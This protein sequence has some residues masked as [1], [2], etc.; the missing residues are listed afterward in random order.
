MHS[1]RQFVRLLSAPIAC[2]IAAPLPIARATAWLQNSSKAGDLATVRNRIIQSLVGD[3]GRDLDVAASALVKSQTEAGT[4]AG[5]DYEDQSRSVWKTAVQLINALQIAG[6]YAIANFAEEKRRLLPA[7][8]AALQWWISHDPKNP[9]WWWNQIGV[10]RFVG[11]TAVFLGDALAADQRPA[12]E[13]IL[14]RAD[15]TKWTGQNLVWGCQIQ[16][17]RGLVT[18]EMKTVEQGFQRMYEEVTTAPP[19]GEGIEPDF[20]FHQH[21]SQL[22]SGGYGLNFAAD[23]G[24]YIAATGT[25]PPRFPRISSTSTRVT[26]SRV[27]PG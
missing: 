13:K 18:G 12:T 6:A 21:R 10:P 26:C 19:T 23:V 7:V 3:V 9:N 20:S 27:R 17:L 1:R 4:W 11:E 5:V 22:Y 24:A 25:R 15:W 14:K 16:V 2:S 8:T